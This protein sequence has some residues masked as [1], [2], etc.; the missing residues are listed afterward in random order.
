MSLYND[1]G[2]NIVLGKSCSQ[3]M[4]NLAVLFSRRCRQV[5]SALRTPKK[6]SAGKDQY[7]NDVVGHIRGDEA[8]YT[9]NVAYVK[10][11]RFTNGID[12]RIHSE[13]VIK[14]DNKILDRCLL[15]NAHSPG[16]KLM[17]KREARTFLYI[18]NRK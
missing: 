2:A 4:P 3:C 14:C 5:S 15:L 8:T 6:K 18:S 1:Q 7:P 17:F 16:F 9:P 11:Y 13:R 12:L 10:I